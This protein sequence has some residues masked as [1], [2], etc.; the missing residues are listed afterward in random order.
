MLPRTDSQKS[1][2]SEE[3]DN[4]LFSSKRS[5]KHRLRSLRK[6]AKNETQMEY[7]MMDRISEEK[8]ESCTMTIEVLKQDIRAKLLQSV[9]YLCVQD[10]FQAMTN[11]PFQSDLFRNASLLAKNYAF[12]W[13]S[14]IGRLD[15]MQLLF[16]QGAD[17][18]FVYEIDNFSAL[19][20]S[21]LNGSVTC[22]E[23]LLSH[24]C[25]FRKTANGLLPLHY[26]VFGNSKDVSALLIVNGCEMPDTVLN[27]AVYANAVDCVLFLLSRK[28]GVNTFDK[29][30]MAPIHIASDHNNISCLRHL[31]EH[32]KI[33][34]NLKTRDERNYAAIHLAAENGYD[35]CIRILVGKG[36]NVNEANNKKETPLHLACKMQYLDCVEI[37]LKSQAI[38]N[39]QNNDERTPLHAAV[40]KSRLALP[41][42]QVMVKWHANVN[43]V[44]W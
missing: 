17:V 30:G 32:P 44:D 18:N 35:E 8:S 39:A 40:S 31:L 37:L 16:E 28:I 20:L 19:H 1:E 23:W 27:S 26:A 9:R 43:A 22:C 25:V 7:F 42:V 36:A 14:Y 10:A 4:R 5:I 34:I 3:G 13:A 2:A 29:D 6:R 15:Y 38:V 21:A 24:G 12:L 11:A 33:L 41:I